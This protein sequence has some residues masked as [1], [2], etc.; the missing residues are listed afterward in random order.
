[1]GVARLLRAGTQRVGADR[2]DY[3]GL[4]QTRARDERAA[5]RHLA[6]GRG[7]VIVDRLITMPDHAGV[8]RLEGLHLADQRR[9]GHPARQDVQALAGLLLCPPPGPAE[10]FGKPVPGRDRRG[11]AAHGLGA[12]RI[13]EAKHHGFEK[14]VGRAQT[15]R[16]ARIAFELGGPALMRHGDG[17]AAIA[18][19]WQGGGE[20]QDFARHHALG[21]L[22]IGHDLVGRGRAT[23][24]QC[25]NRRRHGLERIAPV[26]RQ[27]A[28]C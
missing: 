10:R 26:Q 3:I 13:V 4:G 20:T 9:R 16:M 8:A 23:G 27:G 19:Q 18:A 5:M 2:P 24:R 1:M 17:A 14:D 7:I 6:A 15:R 22:H 11:A 25:G 21:H 12:I 28:G